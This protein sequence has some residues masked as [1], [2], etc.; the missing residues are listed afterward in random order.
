MIYDVIIIGSGPQDCLLIYA[1]RAELTNIVI[2]KT[3]MS[4]AKLLIP[5]RWIITPVLPV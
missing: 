2:E 4:V 5:M 1:Q 3:G